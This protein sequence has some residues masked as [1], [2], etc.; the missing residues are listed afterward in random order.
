MTRINLKRSYLQA[1]FSERPQQQQPKKK[2]KQSPKSRAE[3]SEQRRIER[4]RQRK[5]DTV[6]FSCRETGHDVKTCPKQSDAKPVCYR[7]GSNTHTLSRCKK[8]QDLNNPLPFASCFVCS[9]TGHL[10]GACPQN[11]NGVYPKGGCCKLCKETSHLAKDCPLRKQD[12]GKDA[13]VYGTGREAGADEDDFHILKR[14]KTELDRDDKGE[15][16]RRRMADVRT[17][18]LSGTVK[19]HGIIPAKAKKVVFF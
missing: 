4:I 5:A 1:G 18:A 7:C 15:E 9:G 13:T 11:S 12:S 17:G 8:R 19:A 14:H 6:C 16:R 2:H 3:A 10:A